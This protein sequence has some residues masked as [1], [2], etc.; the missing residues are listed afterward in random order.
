MQKLYNI[1]VCFVSL[2]FLYMSVWSFQW[3]IDLLCC[4]CCMK[5]ALCWQSG[6]GNWPLYLAVQNG[7]L[8]VVKLL[9]EVSQSVSCCCCFVLFLFG[10]WGVGEYISHDF[11]CG[12][13]YN[14][15]PPVISLSHIS[16]LLQPSALTAA[17][18]HSSHGPLQPLLYGPLQLLL[19]PTFI[20]SLQWAI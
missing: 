1:I 6:T 7:H 9:F 18:S 5:C 3:Q 19:S 4:W 16:W 20:R 11:V 15:L 17:F 12:F 14:S 13:L 8:D 10:G 2:F